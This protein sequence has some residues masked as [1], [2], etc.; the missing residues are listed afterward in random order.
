MARASNSASASADAVRAPRT[1]AI[2]LYAVVLKLIAEHDIELQG[3]VVMDVKVVDAGL[4]RQIVELGLGLEEVVLAD[5]ANDAGLPGCRRNVRLPSPVHQA[6]W[7]G[8][9]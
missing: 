3:I 9:V 4:L 8:Q 6:L 5:T 2:N 7:V 1:P